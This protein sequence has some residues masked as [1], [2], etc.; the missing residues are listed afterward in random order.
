MPA[1]GK[2][3]KSG[4]GR[5]SRAPAARGTTRVTARPL[6]GLKRGLAL[7]TTTTRIVVAARRRRPPA[8]AT[9]GAA[10]VLLD[11]GGLPYHKRLGSAGGV[12][13]CRCVITT[14]RYAEC[15]TTCRYA[16]CDGS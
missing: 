7:L 16:E 1:I 8:A 14:C 9:S 3:G 5:R 15:D 11:L 2:G 13:A 10:F 6:S 12:P 4:R